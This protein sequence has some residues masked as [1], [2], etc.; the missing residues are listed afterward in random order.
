MAA[1]NSFFT[2]IPSFQ[3]NGQGDIV[4]ETDIALLNHLEPPLKYLNLEDLEH[5]IFTGRGKEGMLK[6]T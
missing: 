3:R 6:E 5:V 1:L 4:K 2:A